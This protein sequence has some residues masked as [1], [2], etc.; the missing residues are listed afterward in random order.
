MIAHITIPSRYFYILTLV[1]NLFC[2]CKSRV[3]LSMAC[4]TDSHEVGVSFKIWVV[5]RD[6]SRYTLSPTSHLK[7]VMSVMAES[8]TFLPHK[9]PVDLTFCSGLVAIYFVWAIALM[10]ANVYSPPV[11]NLLLDAVSSKTLLHQYSLLT[12]VHIRSPQSS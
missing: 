11:I 2:T 10:M 6:V 8:G 5:Q 4:P 9:Y 12:V 1:L 7:R 3:T